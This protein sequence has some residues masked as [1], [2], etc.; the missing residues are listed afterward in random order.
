MEKK[1]DEE[2][3]GEDGAEREEVETRASV[4]LPDEGGQEEEEP[5]FDEK[6]EEE[7][8]EEPHPLKLE[9]EKKEIALHNLF[10]SHIED[11]ET[12]AKEMA[13]LLRAIDQAEDEKQ[14]VEKKLAQLQISRDDFLRE[15]EKK[16]EEMQKAKKDQESK[17]SKLLVKKEKLE[18]Y[19]DEKSGENKARKLQLEKEIEEI[20]TAL[21]EIPPG[22][23][24]QTG[25]SEES[26]KKWMLQHFDNQIKSMKEKLE[27]PICFDLA[28]TPIFCCHQQ[29]LICSDCLPKVKR[30]LFKNLANSAFCCRCRTA[31]CAGCPTLPSRSGTG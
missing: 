16:L 9:L 17:L 3:D 7:E 27:C 23:T 11:G 1:E 25:T 22:Q 4:E 15:V 21:E 12:K 19:L 2:E 26:L 18:K 13:S 28:S 30:F 31:H 24:G 5:G 29:H 10:E 20:K 14:A 8:N 6:A